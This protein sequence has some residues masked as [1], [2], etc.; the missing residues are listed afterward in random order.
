MAIGLAL[1][2]AGASVLTRSIASMPF[3]VSPLD[4]LTFVVVPTSLFLIAVLACD[5]PARAAA[6]IDPLAILRQQ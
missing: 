5:L 6:D 1:G 3:G 4:P 2:M